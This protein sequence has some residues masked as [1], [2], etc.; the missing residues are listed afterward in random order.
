CV[1]T[2]SQASPI[3]P[4]L[5]IILKD[6]GGATQT[7]ALFAGSPA[8]DAG[9]NDLIAPQISNLDG[10][11]V[12]DAV[13][14]GAV[15]FVSTSSNTNTSNIIINEILADPA[16]GNEGDANGDGTRDG[17]QD[18]FIELINNSDSA[19]DISGWTLSDASGVKHTFAAETIVPA[20]GVIVIFGG[21]TPTGN[22]G[23]AIVQTASSRSLSLNNDGDTV[24]L[25]DGTNDIA[26]YTY[27]AEGGNNQ[28][29][30]RDPDL[31]GSFVLH[32]QATNSNGALFSPGTKLDTTTPPPTPTPG[33]TITQSDNTTEVAEGSETDSYTVVLDSQPT[34]DVTINVST[35]GE[36]TVD[37][38][39]LTFTNSNWDTPQTVTITAVDDTEV[40]N[41]HSDTVSHTISSN[42]TNYSG[43]TVDSIT[44]DIIDND[45]KDNNPNN[46]TPTE[47]TEDKDRFQGTA[48][49]DNVSSGAGNDFLKGEA[50]ND[51]IDAGAD[52]D[53][54]YGGVGEDTLKGGT[55]NDYLNAG[56]DNDSLEGGEGKDRLYGGDGDDTLTGGVGNDFLKG[57]GGNDSLDGGEGKD[58]L[59]G[60]DGDDTL[61]GG[62][63]SDRIEG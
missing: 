63:G 51:V 50:G 55:G 48:N 20:K 27:N 44:V 12:G 61:T 38:N 49:A 29:I 42:D 59:Y 32:S 39:T 56:A 4:L 11:V 24:T 46:P 58:R 43:I 16:S 53:R 17:S 52:N 9:N 33:I 3:D 26:T 19:I 2:W 18:E 35:G 45:V 62:S 41:N 15:E 28:S 36:T 57:D 1:P 10:R 30:T 8:I 7:H 25:N 6:N 40:E 13:D 5:D 21:G 54:V 31:T 22:F 23:D 34:T 60:G 37:L 47:L 14:I